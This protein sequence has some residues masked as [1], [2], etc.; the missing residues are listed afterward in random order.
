MLSSMLLFTIALSLLLFAQPG[1]AP[2]MLPADGPPVPLDPFVE[3]LKSHSWPLAAAIPIAFLI[4][5]T[6]T[7]WL[8]VWLAERIPPWARPWLAVV[9]GAGALSTAAII[10]GTDW[11]VA[12]VQGVEAG[13]A[14]VFA[15][16]VV[17]ANPRAGKELVPQTAKMTAAHG[18]ALTVPPPPPISIRPPV[19][20]PPAA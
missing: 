8:S 20:P 10:A 16:Q 13:F 1:A 12:L 3:A 15:H 19:A 2:I 7:G 17:V 5:L 9:L 11:R 18:P 6:K 14:A 4:S